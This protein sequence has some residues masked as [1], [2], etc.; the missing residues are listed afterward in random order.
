MK[1]P[2]RLIVAIIVA[3]ITSIFFVG[4]SG[5]WLAR[6]S[7]LTAI[8]MLAA[9]IF[10]FSLTVHVGYA[11]SGAARPRTEYGA[12]GTVIRPAK[13]LDP[14]SILGFT[15]GVLA[16]GLYLLF[17]PL[18]LVDYVPRGTLRVGVPTACVFILTFGIAVLYRMFQ[19]GDS[20]LRLHPGGFEI[21]NGL[22]NVFKRGEW[23]EIEQILDRPARGGSIGREMIVLKLP[24]SRSAMLVTDAITGNSDAL[25]EWV[26]FY[27]QHPEHRGE[28]VDNRALQRLHDERF[29]VE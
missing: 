10:G 28:L 25:R 9:G 18:G 6:G 21:W 27:W 22:W 8:I 5:T 13:W 23:D 7:Y 16:A 3:A 1:S 14:V 19:H 20:H 17:A 24:K 2:A 26:R 15:S 4:W 29:V 11:L 12:T